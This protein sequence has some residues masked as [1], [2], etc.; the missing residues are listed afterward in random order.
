MQKKF[1]IFIALFA[2]AI[3]AKA[4]E[5]HHESIIN[6]IRQMTVKEK[7][8]Q[9]AAHATVPIDRLGLYKFN[10]YNEGTHGLL[11]NDQS[12][13]FPHSISLAA[14]WDS[15]LMHTVASAISDEARI[16]Y[17]LKLI[18]IVGPFEVGLKDRKSVV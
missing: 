8:S 1:C 15:D 3:S 9:L 10:W 12:T 6:L 5:P 18:D 16:A 4:L 2:Y 11:L 17:R 13:I 7:I 14:M